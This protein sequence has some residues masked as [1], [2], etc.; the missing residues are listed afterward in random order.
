MSTYTVTTFE[1]VIL[2][3]EEE[4]QE[5]IQYLKNR[6]PDISEELL[7]YPEQVYLYQCYVWYYY[8]LLDFESCYQY[9]RKWV[10]V[11][12]KN[13]ELKLLDPNLYM[14]GYHYMLTATF[15]LRDID[16]LQKH[17]GELENFRK[18]NYSKFNENSKIF[19]FMY[20]HWGRL[21][22]HFLNG[23]FQEGLNLIPR[24]LRRV[25]LYKERIAPHRL[26]VFYYKI[27]WM[28]IGSGNSGKAVPYISK[29]IN[30]DVEDFREDIQSYSRLLFLMI[31]YDL[32]NMAL[33]PYLV[34]TVDRFFKKT[35][36]QNKL[37]SRTLLFFK[38]VQNI[39]ISDRHL[40]LIEF[41]K[42]LEEIYKDP[43]ELRSF[44]Y[45]DI[46]SWVKSKLEKSTTLSGMLTLPQ[47]TK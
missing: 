11:F 1:T 32:D 5:I 10:E 16:R 26:M 7:G 41:K 22:V 21:N 28:Y 45:L 12:E 13:K 15:N 24:T 29:I 18:S 34:R 8:I 44:L 9:A 37:Q 36:I 31:H 42:D 17:L 3:I 30:D 19:S 46:L 4:R 33:L 43:F 47:L 14:R 27:A 40:L 20:V 25:S 38:K 39:G 35:K 2:R 23:S 6:L